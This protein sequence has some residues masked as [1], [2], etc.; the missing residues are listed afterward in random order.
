MKKL[1]K[2]KRNQI[3]EWCLSVL[4]I[5]FIFETGFHWSSILLILA[6]V[7]MAPI[8]PLRNL[9]K[10]WKIK[11]GLAVF[12]SVV[13]FFA[14]VGTSPDITE[15]QKGDEGSTSVSETEIESEGSSKVT[16]SKFDDNKN[17]SK[18]DATKADSQSGSGLSN[19]STKPSPSALPKYKG[20]PYEVLNGNKPSFTKD[21]LTRKA[22]EKYSPLDK[23][24]RCQ[25]AVASLGI[26]TMP[27]EGEKRGSISSIHPTGW[28]QAK[29]ESIGTKDLYNRCH[30]IGWQLSAENANP[31]NLITGT[32]YMNVDGMLPF[33]N[34]VADYIKET[35]NHVAYRVTPIYVGNNLVASGVQIEAYSIE[36]NGDGIY[37]N[38]Y[39][40]NV[41]PGIKINY[42]SGE[43][44][45]P[46]GGMLS[47]NKSTSN[48]GNKTEPATKSP[49][50]P[51]LSQDSRTVYITGG[52]C[53]HYDKDCAGKNGKAVPLDEAIKM[54]KRPCK[55]CAQ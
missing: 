32:R 25:K 16:D 26:E 29:Y 24:G 18:N 21:E 37:F 35:K 47:P 55:K 31:R 1:S 8:K 48:T 43:S 11:N 53:Y 3:I 39:C 2:K 23:L 54:G 50:T 12:L 46:N 28:R 4:F 27:K 14:A 22:Y 17:E 15:P 9:L 52:E 51:P 13:A 10:K 34:M 44:S 5:L 6:A 41:Q 36:D 45:G 38:V 40:F 42:A 20:Q 30:L 7:L 49:N 33:E 19:H